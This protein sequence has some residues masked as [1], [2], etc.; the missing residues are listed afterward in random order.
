[1]VKL[2]DGIVSKSVL[3]SG[4][5]VTEF[6]ETPLSSLSPLCGGHVGHLPGGKTDI[7]MQVQGNVQENPG[8]LPIMREADIVAAAVLS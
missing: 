6:T 1:M 4:E 2:A 7:G 5:V 3:N 8:A